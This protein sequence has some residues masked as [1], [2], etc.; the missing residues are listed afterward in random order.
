MCFRVIRY[1]HFLVMT[2]L[3]EP[4]KN[5]WTGGFDCKVT[6][7]NF[8]LY[9][10]YMMILFMV[11]EF[12]LSTNLLGLGRTDFQSLTSSNSLKKNL[13]VNFAIVFSVILE[14]VWKEFRSDAWN[15]DLLRIFGF[16]SIWV[17]VSSDCER[18]QSS[19]EPSSQWSMNFNPSVLR[20]S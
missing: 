16:N 7:I 13:S 18:F 5:A 3:Q 4:V 17:Q 14:F 6:F 15:I 10:V 12:I 8:S 1:F 2:Y 9:F 11:P 19:F 20:Y